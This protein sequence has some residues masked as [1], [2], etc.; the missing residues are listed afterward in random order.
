[1][2]EAA[3]AVPALAY[4][5]SNSPPVPLSRAVADAMTIQ[6][7]MSVAEKAI[8]VTPSTM[9]PTNAATSAAANVTLARFVERRSRRIEDPT[10]GAK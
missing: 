4:S 3:S 7:I 6:S 1:M 8:P 10:C 2:P 5:S 9:W